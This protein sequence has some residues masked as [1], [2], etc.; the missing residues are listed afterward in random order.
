MLINPNLFAFFVVFLYEVH[1][2]S[3]YNQMCFAVLFNRFKDDF[4]QVSQG[5]N[6]DF[7][8][9]FNLDSL[10]K[11][12]KG[13]II[14]QSYCDENFCEMYLFLSMLFYL[15]EQFQLKDKS[16]KKRAKISLATSIASS[17]LFVTSLLLLGFLGL[18]SVFVP[19]IFSSAF[20]LILSLF[21]FA[22]YKFGD[23]CIDQFSNTCRDICEEHKKALLQQKQEGEQK[24]SI[25]TLMNDP[26]INSKDLNPVSTFGRFSCFL[27]YIIYLN[28]FDFNSDRQLYNIFEFEDQQL[29]LLKTKTGDTFGQLAK[30]CQISL[31]NQNS[32]QESDQKESFVS[33]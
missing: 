18:P 8:D 14:S 22:R 9:Q 31:F 30:I 2:M 29:N 17:A 5:V 3:N 25:E 28:G 13:K 11:H 21:L 19:I 7:N 32:E 24:V 33:N 12:E 1:I 6:P 16:I 27:D 20:I 4:S 10:I 23:D 26:T 15:G